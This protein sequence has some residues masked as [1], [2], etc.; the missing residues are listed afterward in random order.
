MSKKL[1]TRGMILLLATLF[2]AFSFQVFSAADDDINKL[3]PVYPEYATDRIDPSVLQE[4][5]INYY[6]AIEQ[7]NDDFVRFT[8]GDLNSDGKINSADAKIALRYSARL[9]TQSTSVKLAGDT[10]EDG[11]VTSADARKLLRVAAKLDSIVIEREANVGEKF[12]IDTLGNYTSASWRIV[13]MPENLQVK[14]IPV[15]E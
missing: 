10:N 6:E 4:H 14:E 8:P 12:C 11:R 5:L 3:Y 13:E 15:K 9:D 2:F 7:D 1:Y